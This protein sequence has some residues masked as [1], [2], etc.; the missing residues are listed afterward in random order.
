MRAPAKTSAWPFGG[1][2]WAWSSPGTGTCIFSLA[3][4]NLDRRTNVRPSPPPRETLLGPTPACFINSP[5]TWQPEEALKERI[6]PPAYLP[7]NPRPWPPGSPLA[8]SPPLPCPHRDSATAAASAPRLSLE[9]AAVP[10]PGPLHLL[11]LE[12]GT[13]LPRAVTGPRIPQDSPNTI[14]S[15]RPS[16]TTTWPRGPSGRSRSFFFVAHVLGPETSSLL[17]VCFSHYKLH[18]TR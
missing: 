4:H 11:L 10:T 15:E 2:T 12:P 6:S 8:P 14:S 13:L 1:T 5:F 7:L 9:T 17:L 18:G 16:P 3:S